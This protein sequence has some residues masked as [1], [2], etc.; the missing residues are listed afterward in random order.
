MQGVSGRDGIRT[1]VLWP[2]V[3]W[4]FPSPFCPHSVGATF[5]LLSGKHRTS[6]NMSSALWKWEQQPTHK[7]L[8]LP[9]R[10]HPRR[11]PAVASW[12]VICVLTKYE[13]PAFSKT[14]D[15]DLSGIWR[16]HWVLTS[17]SVPCTSR[18]VSYVVLYSH[19]LVLSWVLVFLLLFFNWKIIALQCCVSFCYTTTWI[20]YMYA[21]IPSL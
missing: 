9:V 14:S 20:S 15:K 19:S 21:Y 13:I 1:E 3:Q 4:S 8:P 7:S 2:L 6:P 12:Q 16:N 11:V 18:A 10:G 5:C 17:A